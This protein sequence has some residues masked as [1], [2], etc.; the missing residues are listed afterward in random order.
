[1]FKGSRGAL[2]LDWQYILEKYIIQSSSEIVISILGV[3]L[4][5]RTGVFIIFQKRTLSFI[6][7]AL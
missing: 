3:S 6:R 4:L 1:A 5:P 2:S 7:L